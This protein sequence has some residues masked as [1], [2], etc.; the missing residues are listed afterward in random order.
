MPTG[1]MPSRMRWNRISGRSP[2]L[3]PPAVSSAGPRGTDCRR[4]QERRPAR[5]SVPPHPRRH[6]SGRHAGAFVADGRSGLGLGVVRASHSVPARTARRCA[7]QGVSVIALPAE[8][9]RPVPRWLHVWAIATVL[10]T[11]VLLVLGQ[12][13]TSFKVGMSDP[14]WP[15]EPWYL[16]VVG[17]QEPNRGYL[18]E[19]SH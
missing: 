6:P 11:L 2:L 7:K 15:T 16:F 14:I 10:V 17:W 13:V 3:N 5:D 1:W 4:V 19:H 9:V 18:I 8:S 12:F